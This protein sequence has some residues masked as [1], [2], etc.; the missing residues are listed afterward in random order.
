MQRQKGDSAELSARPGESQPAGRREPAVMKASAGPGLTGTTAVTL[1]EVAGGAATWSWLETGPQ[2]G[3]GSLEGSFTPCCTCS[4]G[5]SVVTLAAMA[6][7][8][9]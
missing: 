4:Q 8:S 2:T 6:F 1:Q 3:R 7:C 5:E 9:I